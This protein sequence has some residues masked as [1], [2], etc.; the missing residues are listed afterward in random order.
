MDELQ[1]S[2]ADT[3]LAKAQ[4]AHY[5]KAKSIADPGFRA[6]HESVWHLKRKLPKS[7]NAKVR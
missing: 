4:A 3:A 5:Q 6:A 7:K 1:T 2:G